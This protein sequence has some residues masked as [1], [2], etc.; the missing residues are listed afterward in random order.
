MVLWLD[1]DGDGMLSAEEF[2]ARR[3]AL[4]SRMDADGAGALSM[5]EMRYGKSRSPHRH[6]DHH[7]TRDRAAA[8]P[9]VRA[10]PPNCPPHPPL[11]R[12]SVE[13][14]AAGLRPALA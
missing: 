1:A 5:E 3:G 6:G 14:L 9:A 12:F 8:A 10:A 2:E 11:T 4:L 13:E 7:G